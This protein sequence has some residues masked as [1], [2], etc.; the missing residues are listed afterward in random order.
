MNFS[1]FIHILITVAAHFT[2][3]ICCTRYTDLVLASL[4]LRLFHSKKQLFRQI[5]SATYLFKIFD[6]IHLSF[7]Y[8]Q[9]SF[10]LCFQI[11]NTSDS[12][13]IMKRTVTI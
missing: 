5:D 3:K 11:C 8:L 4:E 7:S 1:A 10:S 12:E 9:A 6:E 13:S 2:R